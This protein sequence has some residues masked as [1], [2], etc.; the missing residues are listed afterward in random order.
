MFVSERNSKFKPVFH[1]L[2][3]NSWHYLRFQN[4]KSSYSLATSKEINRS[5]K[6]KFGSMSEALFWILRSKSLKKFEGSH[7]E[8]KWMQRLRLC[9]FDW[10]YDCVFIET[11]LI[12]NK[13]ES[14]HSTQ[15]MKLWLCSDQNIEKRNRE[16]Y[17]SGSNNIKK[18]V[19][20]CNAYN[21]LLNCRLTVFFWKD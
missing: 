9:W 20:F 1:K 8:Q 21:R 10:I 16:F 5:M 15:C 2:I 4:P 14:A 17:D 18:L 7:S 19:C 3:C 6:L 12:S 13:W 11:S